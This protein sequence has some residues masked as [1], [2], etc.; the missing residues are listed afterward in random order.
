M[1]LRLNEL[2]HAIEQEE[3]RILYK[4][5]QHS[6]DDLLDEDYKKMEED[7]KKLETQKFE[8]EKAH[9]FLKNMI[10]DL[11]ILCW[12]NQRDGREAEEK[13]Y[14][15]ENKQK[16]MQS[17]NEALTK[18]MIK[19]HEDNVSIFH[20]KINDLNAEFKK[21]RQE[22]KFEMNIKDSILDKIKNTGDTFKDELIL[23][24]KIIM[25]KKLVVKYKERIDQLTRNNFGK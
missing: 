19:E 24:R 20:L 11:E 15:L 17:E 7:K 14:S 8:N 12:I 10:D 1:Q 22:I 3:N 13:A 4:R 16:Y 25:N 6:K 18:K 21:Y 23:L 2:S 9:H 5:N